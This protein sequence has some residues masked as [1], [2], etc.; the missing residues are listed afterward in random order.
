MLA[1]KLTCPPPHQ[2]TPSP[3]SPWKVQWGGVQ[4]RSVDVPVH[5]SFFHPSASYPFCTKPHCLFMWNRCCS[6]ASNWVDKNLWGNYMS[7][8]ALRLDPYWTQVAFFEWHGTASPLPQWLLLWQQ[9]STEEVRRML[10]G[11]LG[12]TYKQAQ[13]FI[14][15]PVAGCKAMWLHSASNRLE[16]EWGLH[17]YL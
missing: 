14:K 15:I 8:S 6:Y 12:Q 10:K 1:T 16:N 2:P 9:H 3:C 4:F 13:G 11:R 7:Q 17:L 5:L